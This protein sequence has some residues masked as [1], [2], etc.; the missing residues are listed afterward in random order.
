MGEQFTRR[1]PR[2]EKTFFVCLKMLGGGRGSQFVKDKKSTV[3]DIGDFF[4][5]SPDLLSVFDKDGE[6]K[7]VNPAWHDLLGWDFGEARAVPFAAYVHPMTSRRPAEE[8]LAV[9]RGDEET[10]RGFT[11]RQRCKDGSY[12][13]IQWSSLRKDGWIPP[14]PRV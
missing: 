8:F 13:T 3:P 9:I 6:L 5:I 2:A 11:N 14:T 12:R 4:W 7:L 10:R 1:M